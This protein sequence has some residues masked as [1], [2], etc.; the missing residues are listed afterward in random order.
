[1]SVQKMYDEM[2][3]HFSR[4]REKRYGEGESA[5]WPVTDTYLQK[6]VEGQAVLDVGCG[7]G[8]LVSGLPEGVHYTGF[9]FSETLLSEAQ[10]LY[11]AHEFLYGN[12]VEPAIW[13]SLGTYE[14]IFCVAVLHHIPHHEQQLFVLKEM[15]CHLAH[16]GF[17]Y[18]TVWNL[19]QE[20]YLTHHLHSAKLKQKDAKWVQIPFMKKWERFC[21][22]FDMRSL[23]ELMIEAGWDVEEIYY[24]DREGERSDIMRGQNL[25]V[26]AR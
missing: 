25:V 9:D 18:L 1:M 5:N 10:K 13:K 24:A 15:R 8:R 12:V 16:G 6:L 26:V 22:A 7:N 3:T 11:P 14:A 4:T 21:V 23:M 17:L 20:R 19:W 2:G